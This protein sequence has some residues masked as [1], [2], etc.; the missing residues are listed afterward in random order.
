MPVTADIPCISRGRSNFIPT[1]DAPKAFCCSRAYLRQTRHRGPAQE[2]AVSLLTG[3]DI[4]C[5]RTSPLHIQ[6]VHQV[7]KS[8]CTSGHALIAPADVLCSP[9]VQADLA[10]HVVAVRPLPESKA[11]GS[12]TTAQCTPK[13]VPHQAGLLPPAGQAASGCTAGL[14]TACC[15]LTFEDKWSQG[16]LHRIAESPGLLCIAACQCQKSC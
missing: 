5:T 12:R 2:H 13:C 7:V 9:H 10:D 16:G 8:R 6:W 15:S 14:V 3:S 1:Y 4:A 11:Q